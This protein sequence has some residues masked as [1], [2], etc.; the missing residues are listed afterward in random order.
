MG[1]AFA[2]S[3][4]VLISWQLDLLL[5]ELARVSEHS[6]R[7]AFRSATSVRRRAIISDSSRSPLHARHTARRRL[8][9]LAR[10]EGSRAS[11]PSRHSACRCGDR[12]LRVQRGGG[13]V[14]S[15]LALRGRETP[16]RVRVRVDALADPRYG[17][18]RLGSVRRDPQLVEDLM[19]L[20]GTPLVPHTKVRL[21]LLFYSHLSK[22][23]SGARPSSR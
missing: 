15:A 19:T 1:T 8:R 14:T 6:P 21:G 13:G 22:A 17:G 3:V 7:L 23:T 2:T 10:R 9:T 5:P 12:R 11:S 4:A 18:C 16:G 20:A